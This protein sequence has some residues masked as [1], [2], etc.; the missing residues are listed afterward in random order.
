MR[1][2]LLVETN[3]ALRQAPVISATPEPA[4]KRVLFLDIDGVLNSQKSRAEDVP[5]ERV[6][7][8]PFVPTQAQLDPQAIVHL[9]RIVQAT[10]CAVVLSSVWRGKPRVLKVIEWFL[11][12]RGFE[13]RLWS[14]TPNSKAKTGESLGLPYGHRGAEIAHFLK[15]RDVRHGPWNLVI[16]DDKEDCAPFNDRMVRVNSQVGL[17]AADASAAIDLFL[18]KRAATS[19]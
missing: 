17:T 1:R 12:V 14:Q 3:G 10:D 13:G 11:Q 5:R 19:S 2:L 9:N 4:G 8:H 6:P 18:G 16:L 7:N 15:Q